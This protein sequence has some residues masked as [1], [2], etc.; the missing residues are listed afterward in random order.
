MWSVQRGRTTHQK[1]LLME[2]DNSKEV[3][4]Q[5]DVA[6]DEFV[7]ESEEEQETCK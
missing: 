3:T 2:I 4:R 1:L 6:A 5:A 7:V